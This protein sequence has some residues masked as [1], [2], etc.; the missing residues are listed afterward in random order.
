M[1]EGGF[2]LHSKVRAV[3]V[4]VEPMISFSLLLTMETLSVFAETGLEPWGC[5]VFFSFFFFFVYV[6]LPGSR[7][8][9]A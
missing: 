2:L 3:V 7:R 6:F 8:V 9:G 1:V 5:S 4:V